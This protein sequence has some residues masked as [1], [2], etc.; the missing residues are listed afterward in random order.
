MGDKYSPVEL[1]NIHVVFTVA[2]F[3]ENFSLAFC[4]SPA[5]SRLTILSSSQGE[6]AFTPRKAGK[7]GKA[8]PSRDDRATT[9]RMIV[10]TTVAVKQHRWRFILF[11]DI[12]Y[13]CRQVKEQGGRKLMFR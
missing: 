6:F 13:V 7:A 3:R 10:R 4:P 9:L 1:A 12:V 5:S 11:T 8:G 2:S